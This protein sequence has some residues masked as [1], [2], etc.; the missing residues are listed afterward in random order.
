MFL[1]LFLRLCERSVCVPRYLKDIV[2]T[3]RTMETLLSLLS[4]CK[5]KMVKVVRYEAPF[6]FLL[7]FLDAV[8][9]ARGLNNGRPL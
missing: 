2:E 4:D 1:D 8:Y 9:S 6:F 5:P 7:F 3:G